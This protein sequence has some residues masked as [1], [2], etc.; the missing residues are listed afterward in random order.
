M[1]FPDDPILLGRDL[2]PAMDIGPAYTRKVLKSNGQVIYRST[3]WSLTVDE[4]KSPEEASDSTNK[5]Q[6]SSQGELGR[7]NNQG[8]LG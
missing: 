7:A 2:G 3:V 6:Q 8:G 1:C 4:L 5:I